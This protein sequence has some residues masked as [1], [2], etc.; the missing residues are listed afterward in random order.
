MSEV[1]NYNKLK[2]APKPDDLFTPDKNFDVTKVRQRLDKQKA[3]DA[4]KRKE[5]LNHKFIHGNK[6]FIHDSSVTNS[7]EKDAYIFTYQGKQGKHHVFRETRG[8]WTQTYTD[9]QLVGKKVQ[10]VI[11]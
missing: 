7:W 8:N 2:P 6:Y 9:A 10:E 11:I 3:E 4:K 5:A 1:N